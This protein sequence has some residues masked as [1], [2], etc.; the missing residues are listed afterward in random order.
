MLKRALGGVVLIA[1][2][3]SCSASPKDD[4]PVSRTGMLQPSTENTATAVIVPQNLAGGPALALTGVTPERAQ[5]L[6]GKVVRVNGTLSKTESAG[7]QV[8]MVH[9][10]QLAASAR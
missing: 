1:I 5:E 9:D 8:I 3:S 4:N 10:I 7:L 6:M 2:L